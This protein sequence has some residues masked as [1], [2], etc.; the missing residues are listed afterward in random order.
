VF[1]RADL[2]VPIDDGRIRDTTRI[3]EALGAIKWVIANGGHPV[4]ASHLGRPKGKR[5]PELT[6]R[7]I[8]EYLGEVLHVNVRL[9]DDC[10]GDAVAA[11]SRS[12]GRT[13][14]SCSRISAFIPARKRTTRRLPARSP[15]SPTS[16]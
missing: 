11:Q 12:L 10:V 6:L 14:F 8:A 4:V 2:N 13:R 5:V 3:D 15:R 1:I 7:P 9:A 16:T